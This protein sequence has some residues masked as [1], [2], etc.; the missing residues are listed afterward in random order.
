M[1]ELLVLFCA[2]TIFLVCVCR[3]DVGHGCAFGALTML[4][5]V[6]MAMWALARALEVGAGELH[7]VVDLWGLAACATHLLCTAR[8]WHGVER[9]RGHR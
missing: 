5:Y 2:A 9:R 6:P 3:I 7:T 4:A 8:R 1:M